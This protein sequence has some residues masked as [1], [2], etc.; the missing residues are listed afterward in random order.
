MKAGQLLISGVVQGD[1][2]GVRYLRGMGKVY[3][4]TW[5]HLRCRVP[6]TAAEKSYTGEEKVRRALL[7]GKKRIN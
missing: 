2:A 7:V 5:Y 1:V 3:G 6:L 4:R